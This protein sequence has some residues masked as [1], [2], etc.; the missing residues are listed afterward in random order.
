[1]VIQVILN[2]KE[3]GLFSEK[4]NR[5]TLSSMSISI[6]HDNHATQVTSQPLKI[7]KAK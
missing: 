1:M 3:S 5:A 2:N 6:M 4:P 7:N